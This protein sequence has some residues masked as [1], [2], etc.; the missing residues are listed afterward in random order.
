MH[1]KNKI[2]RLVTSIITVL[3]IYFIILFLIGKD[4]EGTIE[5]MIVFTLYGFFIVFPVL[6]LLT[7]YIYYFLTL[8]INRME[9]TPFLIK[10]LIVIIIVIAF[11]YIAAI[12]TDLLDDIV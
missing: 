9:R 12:N 10:T 3:L 6:I 7:Y 8:K 4:I 11:S 2:I 1:I 5:S